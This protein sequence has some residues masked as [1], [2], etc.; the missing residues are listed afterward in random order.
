MGASLSLGV[1]LLGSVVAI[2]VKNVS[3]L[4]E[5]NNDLLI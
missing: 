2:I 1:K 5:E 3:E 4:L